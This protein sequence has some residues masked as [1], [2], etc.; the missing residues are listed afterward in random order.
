[1][2]NFKLHSEYKPTGDQPEA[3]EKLING[4]NTNASIKTTRLLP[5]KLHKN[6]AMLFNALAPQKSID[7]PK[8]IAPLNSMI[9]IIAI[10]IVASIT[11][12]PK[13]L[14]NNSLINSVILSPIV[15]VCNVVH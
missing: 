5:R 4:I 11:F 8:G 15:S 10:K 7:I 3:I 6:D 12:S 9:G 1:M 14:E 2:N 13:M